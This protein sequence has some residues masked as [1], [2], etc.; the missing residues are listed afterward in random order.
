MQLLNADLMTEQHHNNEIFI[1]PRLGTI[2]PWS[3]KATDILTNCGFTNVTRIEQASCIKFKSQLTIKTIIDSK[4]YDRMTESLYR[5]VTELTSLFSEHKPVQDKYV[6]PL[7]SIN[8]L[9]DI[10]A[11]LGLA[12]SKSEKKLLDIKLP[13]IAEGA[14]NNRVDDVCTGKFRTLPT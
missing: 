11:T 4:I 13:N 10:D 2:S 7:N 12:L 8:A 6:P 1:A 14:N 5:D 9:D 3:S